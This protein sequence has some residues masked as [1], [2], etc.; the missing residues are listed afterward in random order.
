MN[1]LS[2]IL[3]IGAG[4]VGGITAALMKQQGYPVQLVCRDPELARKITH[5]GLHIFGRCGDRRIRVPA[6]GSL[7]EV[8][9]PAD[10]VF[11]ATKANQ[12]NQVAHAI[13]PLLG[14]TSRVV[15]MQ[16]GIVE[17]AV[18]RIVGTDRTV[19][20]VVGFGATLHEPGV[21]EM[22]SGGRITVGYLDRPAD[23]ALDEIARMLRCV[24]PTGTTDS[25]ISELYAKLIIN[26]CTSTL[27]AISG[28]GL[29]SLLKIKKARQLFLAIA[30][31][32]VQV[33]GAMH[34]TIPPYAGRINYY[35]LLKQPPFIQ[36]LF[37]ILFGLKYRKQRSSN[38]RSLERGRKTEIDFLNGYIVNQGS[39]HDVETPVNRRLVLMVHE[40]ENKRRP[41]TP[42]N[43]EDELL[44]PGH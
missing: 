34:L 24:V 13:I 27:G 25:I 41:I 6:V 19:G 28:L 30:T 35:A 3:I 16:N 43:L 37:I 29:G 38:L 31:E 9:G 39:V 1:P 26:A 42:V 21:V 8:R 17:E 14:A 22:T 10:M 11:I 18:S 12:V 20:C 7:D 4:A 2:R 5:S 33:A 40:I 44:D 15:S 32:A 23:P 36:H